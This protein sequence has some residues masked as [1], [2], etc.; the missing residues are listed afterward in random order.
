MK[1]PCRPIYS[2][3]NTKSKSYMVQ[4]AKTLVDKVRPLLPASVGPGLDAVEENPAVCLGT[5]L[6]SW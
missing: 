5:L 2:F 6:V 3:R 1:A 4:T